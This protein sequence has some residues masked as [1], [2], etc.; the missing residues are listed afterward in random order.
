MMKAN[1]QS[2]GL[3]GSG[4]HSLQSQIDCELPEAPTYHSAHHRIQAPRAGGRIYND[5]EMH[6][7]AV[8]LDRLRGGHDRMPVDHAGSVEPHTAD[9]VVEVV[10]DR[11]F[12][13]LG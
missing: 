7:A 13:R 9:R 10:I 1:F 5:S 4:T 6:T 8:M 12:E 3:I 2:D 11:I